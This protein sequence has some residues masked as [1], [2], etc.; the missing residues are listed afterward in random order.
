MNSGLKPDTD[1]WVLSDDHREEALAR[2]KE[3]LGLNNPVIAIPQQEQG[4]DSSVEDPLV[5][6]LSVEN[7]I[8]PF[9]AIPIPL[10]ATTKDA[11]SEDA[12]LDMAIAMSLRDRATEDCGTEEAWLGV[13]S[14]DALLDMAIAMSMQDVAP[15]DGATDDASK[16][17][18]TVLLEAIIL[19]LQAA[20]DDHEPSDLLKATEMSLRDQCLVA[21]EKRKM[22]WR[23]HRGGGR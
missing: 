11:P 9:G 14:E 2:E 13:P 20:M 4:Y 19:S 16:E 21:A 3:R 6:D 5:E 17:D 10:Q 18:R 8:G 15:E 22:N 12:L 7:R 1:G 23:N